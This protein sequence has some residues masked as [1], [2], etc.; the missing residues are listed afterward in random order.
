[1]ELMNTLRAGTGDGVA[2]LTL[3]KSMEQ[4]ETQVAQ[5]LRALPDAPQ[6]AHLGS[7]IDCYA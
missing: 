2:V 1:M 7:G 3:K 4:Q 5:L 6:P